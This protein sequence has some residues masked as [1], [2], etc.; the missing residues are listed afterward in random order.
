MV[1][2]EDETNTNAVERTGVSGSRPELARL[3][4]F[5]ETVA[6]ADDTF[7]TKEAQSIVHCSTRR[8]VVPEDNGI[9]SLQRHRTDSTPIIPALHTF[10]QHCVGDAIPPAL[11]TL[12]T[13]LSTLLQLDRAGNMNPFVPTIRAQVY[14]AAGENHAGSILPLC[15]TR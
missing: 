11:G 14:A 4:V 2:I 5:V 7:D 3:H 10:Y 8:V 1:K 13:K 9:V 15:T 12:Y 6:R